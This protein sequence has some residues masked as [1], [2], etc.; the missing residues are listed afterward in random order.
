MTAQG[1]PPNTHGTAPKIAPH[2]RRTLPST[3][4][5][6]NSVAPWSPTYMYFSHTT[7]PG[8]IV[9]QVR[10]HIIRP[11]P[12]RLLQ[13]DPSPP[14]FSTNTPRTLF[15]FSVPIFFRTPHTPRTPPPPNNDTRRLPGRWWSMFGLDV[16]QIRPITV[17][18]GGDG[19]FWI[20]L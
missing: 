4:R 15:K 18:G 7:P 20:R 2:H 11:P 14:P 1:N 9:A 10:K 13:N 19:L 17:L 3:P 12:D 16:L 6:C 5:L 8:Q